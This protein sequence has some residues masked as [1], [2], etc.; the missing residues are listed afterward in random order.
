MKHRIRH[1]TK[2]CLDCPAFIQNHNTR[3]TPCHLKWK[4]P[5]Q[6]IEEVFLKHVFK[7]ETCWLWTGTKFSDGRGMFH[8]PRTGHSICAHRQSWI[9]YRGEIPK[10]KLVCHKCDVGHCVNPDHLFLGTSQDNTNDMLQKRRGNA[11][12]HRQKLVPETVLQIRELYASGNHTLKDLGKMYNCH[13]GT[14][15]DA[16][17]RRWKSV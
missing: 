2:K 7:S 3:C 1:L 16:I 11:W 12:G 8:I 6:P 17:H 15:Y 14:I 5:P 9:I 4:W 10:G 13:L